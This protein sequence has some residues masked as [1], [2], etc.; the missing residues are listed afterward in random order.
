MAKVK[1]CGLKTPELVAHAAGA[2]ADWL[3]FVFVPASPRAV[4]VDAVHALSGE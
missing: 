2:G 1:I 4:T 3:G